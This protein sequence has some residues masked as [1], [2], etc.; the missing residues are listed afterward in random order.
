MYCAAVM[1]GFL[2]APDFSDF[3]QGWSETALTRSINTVA[4]RATRSVEKH[5]GLLEVRRSTGSGSKSIEAEGRDIDTIAGAN[6]AK[7]SMARLGY[8]DVN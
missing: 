4:P 7:A 8:T 1:P 6:T 3:V 2:S 5:C